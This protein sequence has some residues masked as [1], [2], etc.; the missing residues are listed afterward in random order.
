MVKVGVLPENPNNLSHP[1]DTSETSQSN[2]T[3]VQRLLIDSVKESKM[4]IR[5]ILF[6]IVLAAVIRAM[7]PLDFFHHHFGPTILGLSLTVL[8]ASI[9]EVCTEGSTPIAADLLNI[10]GAPGNAFAF[11]MAGVSTDYTEILAIKETTKS[12][13]I[14]LFLPLITLPQAI[15][16]AWLLNHYQTLL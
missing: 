14:A 5:W 8:A 10:A 2:R 9:L 6:G 12:L 11:L 4:V 15:G 1:E 3:I 16:L 13:K 7:V